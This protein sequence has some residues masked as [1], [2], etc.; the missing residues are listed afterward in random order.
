M[1]TVA[2]PVVDLTTEVDVNLP[3]PCE[4][5]NHN[6]RIWHEGPA[7][8]IVRTV[9]CPYCGDPGRGTFLLCR[10]AWDKAFKDGLT[11]S[12]C[13][14]TDARETFWALVGEL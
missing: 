9:A 14:V 12:V 10:K 1:S 7:E 2:E 6:E 8:L 3:V 11:C 4:H 5:P 13:G